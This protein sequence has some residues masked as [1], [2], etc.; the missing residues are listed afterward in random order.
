MLGE[1]V[2]AEVLSLILRREQEKCRRPAC[3]GCAR[4]RSQARPMIRLTHCRPGQTA[5]L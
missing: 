2:L 5:T 3:P 4:V 1:L